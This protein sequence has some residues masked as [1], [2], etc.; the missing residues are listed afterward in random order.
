MEALEK[1]YLEKEKETNKIHWLWGRTPV[2]SSLYEHIEYIRKDVVDDM[3]ATAED[4]AYFAGSEHI[5]EKLTNAFIE[6]ACDAYCEVCG[7]YPHTTPD[8]IC[9]QACDYYMRFKNY[10][11][12]E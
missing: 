9:R 2:V 6:K 8:Y 3:L 7:H 5:R 1:I 10:M 11:K 4:H 12:G